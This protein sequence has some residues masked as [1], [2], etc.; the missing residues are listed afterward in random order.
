MKI[1]II[2]EALSKV[3]KNTPNETPWN[4]IQEKKAGWIINYSWIELCLAINEIINKKQIFIYEG[5]VYFNR[6]KYMNLE[7]FQKNTIN[8]YYK[9][10][11]EQKNNHYIN[12]SN[13][14]SKFK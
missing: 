11:I 5:K 9:N 1:L 14:K 6:S 12:F 13:Y 3:I 8:K 4:I 2:L 10:I 7:R